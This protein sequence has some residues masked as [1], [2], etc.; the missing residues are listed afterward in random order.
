MNVRNG[1][2]AGAVLLGLV[3]ASGAQAHPLH[4]GGSLFAGFAHPLLG[5]DHLLAMIAVGAWSAQLGGRARYALP[6]TFVSIMAVGAALAVNGVALPSVEAGIA[7]SLLAL[8]LLVAF[9]ARLPLAAGMALV[10]AFALFHGHAHGA[11]LPAMAS[12]ATFAAGFAVATALLHGAGIA[13]AQLARAHAVRIAGAA[14][15][16]TGVGLLAAL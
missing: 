6:L 10:A 5:P 1:R 13:F 8:G 16:I 2:R 4:A 3:L 9:A 11:E 7:A 14:V 12:A 15:A